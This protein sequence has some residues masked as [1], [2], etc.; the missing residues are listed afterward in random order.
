[1]KKGW[2]LIAALLL[3]ATAMAGTDGLT[4]GEYTE[5]S[6]RVGKEGVNETVLLTLD[7]SFELFPKEVAKSVYERWKAEGATNAYEA[8]LNVYME[9][10]EASDM[11]KS[12]AKNIIT[13]KGVAGLMAQ[14]CKRPDTSFK[15]I[16]YTLALAATQILG[17]QKDAKEE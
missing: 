3:P 4:C 10:K 13:E 15:G 12:V 5:I 16:A 14:Y 6:S 17:E 11:A 9:S 7:T 2:I 8:S 1:M